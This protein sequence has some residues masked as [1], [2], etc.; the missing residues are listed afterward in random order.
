MPWNLVI[1]P[2]LGGYLFV[3]IC[4]VFSY[5]SQRFES[6]RLLLHSASCGAVLV[7]L[8]RLFTFATYR[9]SFG[10]PLSIWLNALAPSKDAPYLGTALT[11]LM[12][13]WTGAHLVN[14][15][16]RSK[17]GNKRFKLWLIERYDSG[18]MRLLHEAIYNSYPLSITLASRKVYIG[19]IFK[20]PA[21][22]PHD[23]YLTMML[24]LSGYRDEKTLV[25]CQTVN[26]A[27]R[28]N[29]EADPPVV[30]LIS[31]SIDQISTAN[32]FDLTIY[33]HEFQEKLLSPG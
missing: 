25:L 20:A 3:H 21:D 28:T 32:R 11:A 16:V 9:T 26:Y 15:I 5:R 2:L 13:G 1:L 18:L 30:F 33:Q 19:Y 12:F 6:E 29:L 7:I 31:F 8:A 4:V 14:A 22:S 17:I 27:E 10:A 23:R 24:L